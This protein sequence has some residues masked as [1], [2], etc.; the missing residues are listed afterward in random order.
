M[1]M[2]SNLKS[3]ILKTA[4]LF[5]SA[6]F[7]VVSC[8]DDSALQEQIDL[9]VNKVY[10]L[11]TQLNNEIA[12]LQSMLKGKVLISDV[13]TDA[14]TG[15]TTVTLTDG[16]TLELLPKADMKSYITY[17]ILGDG[18][19]YWAYIDENGAKQLF[20]DDKNQP[21]PVMA[22]T[23][24]VVE[25]DGETYLEIGGT[26]YPLSGNSVFSDYEVITDELTGEVYAVTFT[27]GEDM[28]FTVTVDGACGMYFVKPSGWSTEIIYD[29]YVPKGLTE[30]I[31]IDARG[32]VD[33]VLQIPDGWRVKEY[34]D[35]YMGTMY[36]EVTAP[37]DELIDA[38]VAVPEGD[39]KVVAVLEGGKATVARL[40][41]TTSPFKSFG[42]S[43]GNVNAA[44]YNGLQKFVY[45]VCP[46]SSFDKAAIY[47]TATGL[48]EAYDYPAGYGL[49]EYDLSAPVEDVIGQEPMA[50]EDYVFWALPALY[51]E[52]M[53][54]AGYYLSETTFVTAEFKYSSVVFE[55]SNEQFR[56]AVLNMQLRGVDAYYVELLPASEYMLED[57]VFC[58]NNG[59]YEP[60]SD[61]MIYTGSIFEFFGVAAESGTDYVAWIAVAEE[62]KQ[63]TEADVVVCEFSTLNLM[64]GGNVTVTAGE[65]ELSTL[66]AVVSLTASGAESLYY[67][68]LTGTDAK[69]YTDDEDKAMYLFENGT[70]VKASSVEA[71][72]SD[73][74]IKVK[75]ETEYVLF[76]V[77]SDADGKYGAVLT[78]DCQT[79][80]IQYNDLTVAIGIT[81]NEPG[82]VRLSIAAD[83]ATGFL[84]W[85]GRTNDNTWKSTNY[86]GGNAENAQ[87]FMYVN[88]EH[89]RL[90][91]VMSK[92]PVVDGTIVLED[93]EGGKDYVIVAMAKEADGSYSKATEFRFTPR[94]V[95]IGEVVFASDP[96]WAAAKPTLTWIPE[97]FVQSSGG[98]LPGSYAYYI[99]IP[100]GFTAYV[101]SATDGYLNNGD[102]T[103][104]L[105][106]EE[107]IV[108]I[109]QQADRPRDWHLTISEDWVWPHIGY[110]HYH[111][112]HGAELWGNSVIWASQEFHDSKCNCGGNFV[113]QM[114][115][116][117]HMVEVNHV[118]NINTGTPI[119]FRMPQAVASTEEV[120]DKVFVVCQDLDGNCY[121]KFTFDVPI[122]YFANAGGRDQ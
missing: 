114:E 102:P 95:S 53:D 101:L 4:V 7:A 63:Y 94:A 14:S 90:T 25:I 19:A 81:R 41:L 111:S 106:P 58:L 42:F 49:A 70:M 74:G 61:S 16:T 121:E 55:V 57:V 93:L 116:Q 32:V 44:M 50:G 100:A 98:I 60:V 39:L 88:A 3:G 109:I 10:E 47:E 31:Q 119:E 40:Y 56:D 110:I 99:T 22:E 2:F 54:D 11:E 24:K 84:Y 82:D 21:I 71:K 37:S 107:E 118:I 104:I 108:S 83:G 113:Q 43:L 29:Y 73:S 67:A 68:F 20:K 26:R 17:L 85:I 120:T 38:G 64:A 1:K 62:G 36:F 72:L 92:Y 75:P 59:I 8:Y 87:A 33:Y 27:F 86:L 112:Q 105:T 13:S 23:P 103:L 97:Q 51:Y 35:I 12:A 78:V 115:M 96:K 117:G 69:R 34:K 45:G 6:A 5:V 28:T 79:T 52:T 122:E 77:A 76:A 15:V 30:R 46:K 18:K 80:A 89:S 9:L 91:S 66:N 65:P 48:L